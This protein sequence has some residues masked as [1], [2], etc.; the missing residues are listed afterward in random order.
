MGAI[1]EYLHRERVTTMKAWQAG[2]HSRAMCSTCQKV[3][4]TTFNFYDIPFSDYA[5]VV[6]N[7]IAGACDEC[8]TVITI[9]PQSTS[10][11][12]SSLEKI[13]AN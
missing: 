6:K 7:I 3:V 10:S 1:A 11:I 2:D 9:P 8:G 12:Q 4:T 5:S 13:K